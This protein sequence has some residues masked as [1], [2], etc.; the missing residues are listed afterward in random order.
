MNVADCMTPNVRIA[1]PKESICD[2]AKAMKEAETGMLPVGENNRLVGIVTDRDIVLRAIAEG[3]GPD[4]CVADVMSEE[5]L[6]CYDDEDLDA[7]ASKMSANQVR[8]LPVINRDKRLVGVISLGDLSQAS[9]DD[10]SRAS[11]AL[12]GIA[13]AGGAHAD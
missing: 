6:Y 4:T 2:A 7:A 10:G 8:R 9:D 12:A 11:E 3:K 13:D 1:S 5:L